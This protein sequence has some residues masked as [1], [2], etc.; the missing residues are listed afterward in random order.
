MIAPVYVL[1]GFLSA[2]KTSFL[3]NLLRRGDWR[4]IKILVLQFEN[5]ETELSPPDDFCQKLQFT[6][7]ELELRPEE[8]ARRIRRRLRD[9]EFDEVWVEW[10][11]VAPFAS[12]HSLLLHPLLRRHCQ[13]RRVVHIADGAE[14]EKLL[15]RTGQALPGQI[16]SSDFAL[17]RGGDTA[18]AARLR[19]L[20]RSLNPGLRVYA[21]DSYDDFYRQLLRR[22]PP[23]WLVFSAGA[24][25]L[26]LLYLL[27]APPLTAAGFPV[28]KTV[29]VFLGLILQALPFLLIGV[30]ISGAIEIFVSRAAIESRFPKTNLA[31]MAT[32]V[33]AGFCLPVCDCASIPVFHG[34]VRKGVP[35][36]AAV[37]FLT[38]APVINPIVIFSTYY[39]FN[40]DMRVVALRAILGLTAALLIG[41]T[42]ALAPPRRQILT[43][44]ALD[45]LLC[46]CG[47]REDGETADDLA[48]KIALLFR[49][50]QAEFFHMGKYL[51]L[52]A[53]V[54]AVI[55][56]V[57][58]RASAVSGQGAGLAL[59]LLIMMLMA[60]VLSLCS[61]SDA[62]IARSFAS[63]FPA[64][65]LMGF[66]VF[67]PMMD[68]KNALLLSSVFS[69]RFIA[70]LAL[71]AFAI[72]FGL[73]F[74]FN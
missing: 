50:A 49:H 35:L 43:G 41:L 15:G 6:I 28:N 25:L 70:R 39:A 64:E 42:F 7:A 72:C 60:F 2:G 10:N 54:S 21:I 31:G 63:Q 66:M 38:A 13:M 16:A 46:S 32:A 61:S 71:T 37:T 73:V 1:T 59:S 30:L 19:K 69:G 44:G 40:G 22:T 53:F 62:V 11:G 9:G 34:L 4:N 27:A 29:T 74:L 23:A 47:C 18:G 58:P 67:G 20:L 5:G 45:R 14:L 24:I 57:A 56:A 12:L 17:L 36:P 8:A 26:S 68:I 33:I 51:A 52:G 55:Q 3:N 65:A 48:G